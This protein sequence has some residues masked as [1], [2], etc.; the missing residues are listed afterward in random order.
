MTLNEYQE[1]AKVTAVFPQ[2]HAL[3]YLTLGLAGEAGEVA[4]KA[5]K[6]I[7]GDK[8]NEVDARGAIAAE[9]GDV[10]WY[11]AVLA[12]ELDVTLD[13]LAVANVAKLSSRSKRN[14]IKGSGDNR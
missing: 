7:R 9:L 1:K 8:L 4:N 12:A 14:Q 2:E 13:Q 3:A 6:I 5:K 11:L 10:L